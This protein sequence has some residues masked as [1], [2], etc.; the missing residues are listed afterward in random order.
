MGRWDNVF[1]IW[2][3]LVLAFAFAVTVLAL[4]QE[5]LAR[6][7]KTRRLRLS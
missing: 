5:G 4:C 6:S 1:G 2:I 3:A 7:I